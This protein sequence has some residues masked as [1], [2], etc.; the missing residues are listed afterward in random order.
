MSKDVQK[1]LILIADKEKPMQ[2]SLSIILENQGFDVI[3][4]DNGRSALDI[5]VDGKKKLN[6]VLIDAQLPLLS[7]LDILE[8][9]K[10]CNMDIP[11]I[12]VGFEKIDD[13]YPF[14][15]RGCRNY[16][17]KPFTA[18]TIIASVSIALKGGLRNN[19]KNT[20]L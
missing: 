16:I 10:N 14:I 18:E 6:L 17:E 5:I 19:K 1:P 13:L 8:Y 2:R 11:C 9:M 20:I 7:S 15:R 12:V 3:V 4:A